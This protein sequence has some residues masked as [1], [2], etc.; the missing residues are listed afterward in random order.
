M[1][2][3]GRLL[4]EWPDQRWQAFPDASL[5]GARGRHEW[6]QGRRN[7][8]APCPPFRLSFYSFISKSCRMPLGPTG[9]FITQG[10]MTVRLE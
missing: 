10:T 3:Q 4:P 6:A 9:S 1:R 8:N 7:E 5:P 2:I